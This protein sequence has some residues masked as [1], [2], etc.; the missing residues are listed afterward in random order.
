[1]FLKWTFIIFAVATVA[2]FALGKVLAFFNPPRPGRPGPPML[3]R[4]QRTAGWM[5]LIPFALAMAMLV[6]ALASAP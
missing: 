2:M 5:L 4:V 3:R 1:M 6:I